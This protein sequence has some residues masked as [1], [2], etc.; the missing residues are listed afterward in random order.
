MNLLK[1]LN[2][3]SKQIYNYFFNLLKLPFLNNPS[4]KIIKHK[5]CLTNKAKEKYLSIIKKANIEITKK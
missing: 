2:N 3:Y 4:Y 5:D 1:S